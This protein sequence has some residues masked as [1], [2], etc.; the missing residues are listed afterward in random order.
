MQQAR[1]TAEDV[2]SNAL[3]LRQLRMVDDELKERL[4][5]LINK[6]PK[7]M[8]QSVTP[9]ASPDHIDKNFSKGDYASLVFLN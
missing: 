1:L 9:Y 8:L 6:F 5:L 2:L 7:E 3:G 4:D